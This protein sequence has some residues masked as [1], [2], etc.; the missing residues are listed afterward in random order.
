MQIWPSRIKVKC[1]PNL[2][3]SFEQTWITLSPQCSITRFS[4]EAFLVLEK[5]T[6]KCFS[7]Y[8]GMAA[9]LFNHAEWFEQIDNMPSTEGQLWYLVKFGQAVLEMAFKDYE[10]LYMN[11][12]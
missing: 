7:P 1:Q 10:S 2:K 3:S 9:I 6:F 12:A 5:K 8:V 4:L 11:I